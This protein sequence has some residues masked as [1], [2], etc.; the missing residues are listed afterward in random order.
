MLL[1]DLMQINGGMYK[2]SDDPIFMLEQSKYGQFLTKDKNIYEG[3]KKLRNIVEGE[4]F[5][6]YSKGKDMELSTIFSKNII[7][8]N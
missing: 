6:V 3:H 2:L 4:T 8:L 7:N 1:L 5:Q